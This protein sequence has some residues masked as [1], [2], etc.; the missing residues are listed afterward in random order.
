M[1]L[2]SNPGGPTTLGRES[3]SGW[4]RAA[5]F[6][7][8]LMRYANALMTALV[9]SSSRSSGA[10]VNPEDLVPHFSF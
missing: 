2:G 7:L 4:N 9:S 10:D 8:A 5:F 3:V 1:V 6:E